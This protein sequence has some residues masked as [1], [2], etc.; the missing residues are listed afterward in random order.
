MLDN[1]VS[2][3]H[4]V[5]NHYQGACLSYRLILFGIVVFVIHKDISEIA[6]DHT[7]TIHS[8]CFSEHNG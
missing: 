1:C 7:E 3:D 5:Y 4:G 2:I 8:L 6:E